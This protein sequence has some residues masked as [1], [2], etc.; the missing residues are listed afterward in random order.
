MNDSVDPYMD[1]DLKVFLLVILAAIA[2]SSV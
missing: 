2:I 1:M